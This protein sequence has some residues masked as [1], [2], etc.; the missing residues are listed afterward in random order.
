MWLDA[1]RGPGRRIGRQ[2]SGVKASLES[3]LYRPP[4]RQEMP[5]ALPHRSVGVEAKGLTCQDP[6]RAG[7]LR[8]PF[9]TA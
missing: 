7:G 9:F 8:D 4:A 3:W 2:W 5:T 1:G 6:Q